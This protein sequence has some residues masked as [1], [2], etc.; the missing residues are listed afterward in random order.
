MR[1]LPFAI[2][3]YFFNATAVT[4][5]K[6]LLTKSIPNPLLYIFY[7]SA[8]SAFALFLL[9]WS[10]I[11]SLEAFILGSTSTVLWT[12]GAYFMLKALQAGLVSRVIPVIGTLIPVILLTESIINKTI[13]QNEI[14]AVFVLVLG[15]IFLT[16]LDWRGSITKKEVIFI[17]LSATLYAIS[18]IVLRQA[19]LKAD[20]ITILVWSRFI[21][22]PVSIII[23][24]IPSLKRQVFNSNPDQKSF[25]LLSKSGLIFIF[26]QAAGGSS[27][28]LIT[29]SISL[30]SPALVNS[31][32]GSQYV[33][34]FLF[35]LILGKKFPEV[36]KEKYSPASILTKI[37]GILFIGG[38]LFL[39]AK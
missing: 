33:F 34:I 7:F 9:P 32:Q 19:Y 20:F 14:L 12:T 1:H 38:G 6:F 30:A 21:I 3:A 37:I 11:P 18:Y 5:D 4:V 22:L 17:L 23:L 15:L 16:I 28:L 31:L 10:K 8:F 36:F 2:S 29:Y 24:L 25:S 27:E 13:T 39:M 26:G 35:S